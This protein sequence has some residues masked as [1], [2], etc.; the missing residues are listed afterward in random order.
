MKKVFLTGGTGFVGRQ[1]IKDLLLKGYSIRCLVRKGSEQKIPLKD[2]R[3]ESVYG[4]IRNKESLRGLLKESEAVI[5]LVGIIREFPGKNITF[6]KI[7]SLGAK[8]L[9]E[10]AHQE[11]VKQFILMSALGADINA[12]TSYY[13]TKGEAEEYLK[14]SGL[15]FTIIRP[16]I[17]FGT[18]DQFVNTFAHMIRKSPFIP[19]IGNGQ[20]QLQP[21]SVKN[22]SEAFVRSLESPQAKNRSF[23]AGGPHRLTFDKIID[24]IGE[25]LKK[26]VRKIHLP[27]VIL[28]PFVMAMQTFPFFPLTLDQMNML[29]SGNT[30]DEKKFFDL[31]QIQPIAFK[32]EIKNYLSG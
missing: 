29:L 18:E 13:K 28:K 11:K 24:L 10:T 17:I 30:C 26:K 2:V 12:S 32:E 8:N 20:Y 14:A 25:A 21:I 19:I 1:I 27:V 6:H 7:H 15:P 4:D 3:I 22:V 23:D 5:H 16:S 31:F 9:I